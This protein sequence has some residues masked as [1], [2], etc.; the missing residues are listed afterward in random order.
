MCSIFLTSLRSLSFEHILLYNVIPLGQRK[1]VNVAME[2]VADPSLLALDEPTSGLDSTT[3]S[4]LCDTLKQLAGSGVNVAAVIHQPKMDILNMFTNVLLLG[5]GGRTCYMGPA[6]DMTAYFTKIGFPLPPY[7]NP[8]DYYMDVV[9]GMV[10]IE[11]VNHLDFKKE[12]LFDLWEKAPANP[13]AKP[14]G[15]HE[16]QGDTNPRSSTKKKAGAGDYLD[17]LKCLNNDVQVHRQTAG[18]IEQTYLLFRRALLQRCR[19]P[20]NT[21]IPMILA[22]AA[23]AL[24]ANFY[25]K[26]QYVGIPIALTKDPFSA[27]TLYGMG[28]PT[29]PTGIMWMF[30]ALCVMLIS[31][32][33]LESFGRERAV[34]LRESFSG[35]YTVSY[36][37]AKTCESAIWMPIH[38]AL[39][40]S[41]A[42]SVGPL[43]I[44]LFDFFFVIY[45]TLFGYYG[46]GHCISLMVEPSNRG[47]VLLISILVL[48]IFFSGG[49]IAAV[50]WKE[51]IWQLFFPFWN[52][53]SFFKAFQND[54]DGYNV[55]FLNDKMSQYNLSFSF[56]FNILCAFLTGFIWHLFSLLILW[57][58]NLK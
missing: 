4:N 32:K 25:R 34:C 46:V 54:Y 6:K 41:V 7:E 39:F 55:P 57:R 38:A 21:L 26:V 9:A 5:V 27:A 15:K 23:G 17:F 14:E 10:P 35:T 58:Q 11:D 22:I 1:R 36:W 2:L 56:S 43:P 40:V 53:Q 45:G 50:G 51:H 8:A 48:V 16:E 31:I 28:S 42:L 52:G 24:I 47:L 3:S 30:T 44:H 20:R 37:M 19:V 18:R 49:I 29:D 33:S 13:G 12:D